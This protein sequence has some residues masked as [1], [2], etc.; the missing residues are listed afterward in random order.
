MKKTTKPKGREAGAER[1]GAMLDG[2]TLE[3]AAEALEKAARA[4]EHAINRADKA[5]KETERQRRKADEARK[6]CAAM[7]AAAMVSENRRAMLA[8]AGAE[9]ADA[10]A[11]IYGTTAEAVAADWPDIHKRTRELAR[12]ALN[13]R[14][15]ARDRYDEI[16]TR[17][18]SA[19]DRANRDGAIIKELRADRSALRAALQTALDKLAASRGHE[20]EEIPAGLTAEEISAGAVAAIIGHAAA[21]RDFRALYMAEQ[22]SHAETARRLA[23]RENQ[24]A[25][26]VA[27][28]KELREARARDREALEGASREIREQADALAALADSAAKADREAKAD[29]NQL[30]AELA[31][32]KSDERQGR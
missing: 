5:E 6:K 13:W 1:S 2:A 16:K 26:D 9:A 32:L 12:E 21:L 11:E 15:L 24:T 19:R 23:A 18:D 14:K 29:I 20:P 31:A 28:I 25:R 22:N 3:Q 4:A 17:A 30:R 7:C 8:A 10:L 27:E